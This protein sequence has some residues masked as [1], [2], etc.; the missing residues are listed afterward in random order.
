ML[1]SLQITIIAKAAIADALLNL[2]IALS[3]FMLYHYYQQRKAKYLY[4][5]FIFI[6]FGT[7]T[8]GPVAIMIPFVVSAI[9]FAI[10]RDFKSWLK[11]LF[12]PTGILLFLLIAAPWYLLEYREQGEKFIDGFFLKHNLKRFESPMEGH[13]GSI[14]YYIPVVLI[15]MLPFTSLITRLLLKIKAIVR[16]DLHLFLLLWFA[17]VFLFFSFSGTKLPHYVIYGYTPLFVLAALY[18][19]GRVGRF[20]LSWPAVL[21]YLVLIAL[22]LYLKI[23]GVEIIPDDQAKAILRDGLHYFD[24]RYFLILA[25]AAVITLLTSVW[26]IS[27]QER[28]A[29]IGFVFM[30]TINFVVLPVIGKAKQLPVKEAAMIAKKLGKPV[31][32]YR[33]TTPSFN[34][35][36]QSL[37]KR[38]DPRPGEVVYTKTGKLKTLKSYDIIYQN[39]GVALIKLKEL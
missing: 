2:F 16:N 29:V 39:G 8:K 6:A 30:I 35:Y 15:G 38:G 19:D 23:K 36:L 11:A 4:L 22:P 27:I 26:K 18:L 24:L 37:T 33:I 9:F 3:M 17:F 13:F 5:T 12:N 7:L 34:F 32:S 14:F 20:S 25:A 31:T 1:S 28:V 21:L 10:K